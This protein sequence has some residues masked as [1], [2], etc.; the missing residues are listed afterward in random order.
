MF[1]SK[2]RDEWA[3]VFEGT[4]ACVAP[5]LGLTEA[6]DHPHNLARGVF[7]E[8]DG[9]VQPAPAPRFDRTANELDRLPPTPGQHTTEVLRELGY[10]DSDIARL[11][12]TGAVADAPTDSPDQ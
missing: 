4:D 12:E 6:P 2:T 1:L 11:I 7:V 10:D 3:R 9:I 8:R 5:V